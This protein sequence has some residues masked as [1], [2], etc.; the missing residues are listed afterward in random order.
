MLFN[1]GIGYTIYDAVKYTARLPFTV[2]VTVIFPS[3]DTIRYATSVGCRYAAVAT[4]QRVLTATLGRDTPEIVAICVP[5]SS[6][7]F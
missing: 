4:P 7:R 3:A 5:V 6:R 2:D 1:H